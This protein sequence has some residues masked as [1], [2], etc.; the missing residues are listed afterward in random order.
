MAAQLSDLP[1]RGERAGPKEDRHFVTALARG[2]DVLA[3]FKRNEDALANSEI[4]ARCGLARSTVSRLTYTLTKLGY[5]HHVPHSGAYRLGTALIALGATALAGLDV[6]QIARPG[7]QEL[8]DFAKASVGLGVRD[9]LSMRYIECCRGEV[10]IALNIDTGSRISMARSAMGRA[11][12][13]AC[14]A[15]ERQTIMDDFRSVDDTAWP[16]LR[17]GIEQALE[18]YRLTGCVRS[19]GDWQPTV[20]AIAVAFHP[21]GGLPPMTINCGA[22]TV[23]LDPGFLLED[24]RP[25]L[26]ALA[27]SL[28]GVMGS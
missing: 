24:V 14:D 21:G 2:L 27:A 16:S 26:I 13:A 9:R 28:E 1:E 4:A 15:A 7:M 25:R 11:Y 12:L 22:P 6:R 10:A 17:E 3:C 8:A 23:I 19:F 18:E 5:L 20:S